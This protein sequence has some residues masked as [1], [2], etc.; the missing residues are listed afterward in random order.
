MLPGPETMLKVTALPDA[1]PVAFI[2]KCRRKVLVE[3]TALRAWQ[4]L[5]EQAIATTPERLLLPGRSAESTG[6]WLRAHPGTKFVSRDQARL[7][8]YAAMQA[9]PHSVSGADRWHLHPPSKRESSHP[10]ALV[11]NQRLRLS[12]RSRAVTNSS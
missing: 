8:V 2:P 12:C 3:D 10:G 4:T 9:A 11:R 5:E 6:K 1:P 7:Y